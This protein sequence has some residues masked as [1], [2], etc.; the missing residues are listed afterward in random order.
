MHAVFHTAGAKL[1]G[2]TAWLGVFAVL[3]LQFE[4]A[5]HAQNEHELQFE[6]DSHCE[7]CL[8]LD[9]NGNAPPAQMPSHKTPFAGSTAP[10]TP[11]NPSSA[12]VRYLLP[13]HGPPTS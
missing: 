1:T 8:K 5:T 4:F 3:L 6:A 11:I 10:A 7:V 13:S 2:S 9:N 12:A